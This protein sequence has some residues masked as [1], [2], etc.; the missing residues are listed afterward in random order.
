MRDA[1]ALPALL[2]C[3]FAG[4]CSSLWGERAALDGVRFAEGASVVAPPSG[5]A[6]LCADAPEIC[7]QSES[8]RAEVKIAFGASATPSNEIAFSPALWR[9]LVTVNADVN[10]L[11]APRTDAEVYG[12]RE[13]WAMPLS[14]PD[15]WA[16]RGGDCE[17][18]ALE[19]RERLIAAGLAPAA[20]QFAVGVSPATGRHTVLI[21]RTD[22]GD[23]VLDNLAAL[24]L[25]LGEAPYRWVARQAGPNVMSWVSADLDRLE[26]EGVLERPARSVEAPDDVRPSDETQLLAAFEPLSLSSPQTARR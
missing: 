2:A 16:R 7:A 25:P 3:A 21:V 15:L 6:R 18:Y 22:R 4:G 19:K 9:L 12:R 20:L 14:R 8:H 1:W 24:P 17:D 26:A 5:L 13:V 11:I 23:V 10:W